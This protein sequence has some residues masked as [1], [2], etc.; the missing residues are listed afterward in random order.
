MRK[1]TIFRTFAM[2]CT[3]NLVHNLKKALRCKL[4]IIQTCPTICT[5]REKKMIHIIGNSRKEL[6][7]LFWKIV[8]RYNINFLRN[9]SSL[10]QFYFVRAWK[11]NHTNRIWKKKKR[12]PVTRFTAYF[13]K[14]PK[15]NLIIIMIIIV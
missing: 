9:W 12:I 15:T 13:K 4:R 1:F 2:M 8:I 5:L 11:K 3:T 10:I 14:Y 7:N 6:R